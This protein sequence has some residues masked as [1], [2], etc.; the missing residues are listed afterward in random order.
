MNIDQLRYLVTTVEE[1]SLSAAAR[2]LSVTTQCVSKALNKLEAEAGGKLLERAGSGATLTEFGREFFMRS[3]TALQAFDDLRAFAANY[4]ASGKSATIS[5]FICAPHFPH[6]DKVVQGLTRFVHQRMGAQ[7]TSLFGSPEECLDALK[8]REVDA[9]LIIGDPPDD[10]FDLTLLGNIPC[11]IQVS[12]KSPLAE[13][14]PLLVSDLAGYPIYLWP[15]YECFTRY[16]R[17]YLAERNLDIELTENARGVIATLLNR[18]AVTIIPRIS[19]LDADSFNTCAVSFA[20][21]EQF[22]TPVY[23]ATLKDYAS[24]MA[25]AMKNMLVDLAA[26]F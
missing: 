3:V 11:G 26:E 18:N 16:I 15:G 25:A 13:K 5:L 4:D 24:P 12:A 7:A 6:T 9:G 22:A 10:S 2:K 23:M 8:Q 14:D 20:A 17:R 19:S 1:G 21:S